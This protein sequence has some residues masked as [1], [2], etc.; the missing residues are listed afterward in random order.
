V[1][2]RTMQ[3]QG[4]FSLIEL[5]IVVTVIGIIAS[6]AIPGLV[7]ALDKAKQVATT[8]LLRAFGIALEVYNSDNSQYPLESNIVDAISHLAP[9]SDTL[10]PYDDWRHTVS[11]QTDGSNYTVESFGKDGIDGADITPATRY[12]FQLDI[13]YSNGAFINGVE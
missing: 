1:N 7:N 11:Y 13:R 2:R 9:Y 12:V 3:R 6:I 8:N 4:G 5:L 10:R